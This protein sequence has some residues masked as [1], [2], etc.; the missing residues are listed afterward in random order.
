M[1]AVLGVGGGSVAVMRSLPESSSPRHP[2]YF[3]A[4]LQVLGLVW[5]VKVEKQQ[6]SFVRSFAETYLWARCVQS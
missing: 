4:S 5:D 1:S 3:L 6:R 2:L